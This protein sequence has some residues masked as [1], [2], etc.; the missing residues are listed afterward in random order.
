MI[1]EPVALS[2][3]T[4]NSNTRAFGTL[5]HFIGAHWRFV[6]SVAV[7]VVAAGETYFRLPFI[8]QRLEYQPDADIGGI[9]RPSQRGYVWLANMSLQ[10]P[11]I[12]LNRDG[13]R[14]AETDWSRPVVLA[15]GDSEWFGAGVEDGQV[16]TV[17]LQDDLRGELNRDDVQVVNASH[18]G[19]GP[20]H[21]ALVLRRLLATRHLDLVLVRVETNHSFKLPSPSD[22]PRE[23]AAAQR[24]QTMRRFTKF[25]PYLFDK[26]LAQRDGLVEALVPLF[27][28]GG[29][30]ATAARSEH[31]GWLEAE[32]SW[33]ELAEIASS[34]AIPL[35][36]VVHDI[37]G[38]SAGAAL[39]GGL[40]AL[41]AGR[42]SLHVMR[43]D[44]AALGLGNL[45]PAD[46]RQ[47]FLQTLTLVRDPHA[48]PRQH[49]LIAD[50]ILRGLR[51]EGLTIP[52]K[53]HP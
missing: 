28:R 25:G 26:A 21:Y 17:L 22:R 5:I 35:L 43:I 49:R 27:L 45:A 13:H 29:R 48:N 3:V 33:R 1:R 19:F 7:L 31:D 36:F 39:W 6:L 42:S 44:A 40:A 41:I 14:G 38:G 32:S 9:L 53:R 12:T 37:E 8:P 15:L 4:T 20:A 46:R 51:S 52:L 24:R 11:P 2:T 18:P 47:V 10:T 16:W 30:P 23:F 34:H 50:A